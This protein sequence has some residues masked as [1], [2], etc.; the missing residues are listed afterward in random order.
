MIVSTTLRFHS[1]N[2]PYEYDF[3]DRIENGRPGPVGISYSVNVWDEDDAKVKIKCSEAQYKNLATALRGDVI[4]FDLN[5][6]DPRME[7][8]G[9]ITRP[10]ASKSASAA[11]A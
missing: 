3:S 8:S 5:V 11:A 9:E 7:K 1:R 2:A 4:S 10:A 6:S